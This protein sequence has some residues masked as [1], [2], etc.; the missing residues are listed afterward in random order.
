[1]NRD[2][3]DPWFL[4]PGLDRDMVTILTHGT[5]VTAYPHP[6]Q[7]HYNR[8]GRNLPLQVAGEASIGGYGGENYRAY[9]SGEFT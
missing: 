4:Y 7:P 1:M 6:N 9:S 2:D 3:T 5:D 8:I